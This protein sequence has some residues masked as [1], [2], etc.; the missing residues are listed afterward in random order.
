M[1]EKNNPWTSLNKDTV[2]ENSWIKVEHHNVLNPSNKK[3]IYG[4]VHFKNIAIGIIP[5]DKEGFTWLVGQYRYPLKQYSWE[6][7]EGGGSLDVPPLDSAKRELLEETGIKAKKWTEIQ[8]IHT[9]NS[10]SD[11]FGLIY[12]AEELSFGESQPEESE[13]LTIKKISVKDAYK[14]V[15]D[16]IITDSLSIAGIFKLKALCPYLFD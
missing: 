10:V 9:S 16:G 7:P 2:Y 14:M 13:E 11:E 5:I 4:T 1:S 12:L 15:L 6:I 8:Q 3:G